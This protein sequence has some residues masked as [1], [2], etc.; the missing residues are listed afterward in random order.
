MRASSFL[1]AL[2]SV[3]HCLTV[4]AATAPSVPSTLAGHAL[5]LWLDAFNSGDRARAESFI[6]AHA[7][8]MD[9]DYLM[10]WRAESGV[11]IY[12]PFTP[13]IKPMSSFA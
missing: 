11:T 5:S 10:R 13:V 6:E 2:V 9:L 8:W 3:F 4:A 7:S 12:S 1:G